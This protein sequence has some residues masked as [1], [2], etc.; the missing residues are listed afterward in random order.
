MEFV[1]SHL[2]AFL[3]HGTADEQRD[4]REGTIGNRTPEQKD[5]GPLYPFRHPAVYGDPG[6]TDETV[7]GLSGKEGNRIPAYSL[8]DIKR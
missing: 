4:G 7:D 2:E 3:Q 6:G 1:I 8:T 5:D